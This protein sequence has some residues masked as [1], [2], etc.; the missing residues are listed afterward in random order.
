MYVCVCVYILGVLNFI[1]TFFVHTGPEYYLEK[2]RRSVPVSYLRP[3]IY[4]EYACAL[5]EFSRLI[6]KIFVWMF[7]LGYGLPPNDYNETIEFFNK[8]W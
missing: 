7:D 8:R 2:V 4:K 5:E 1:V 3:K 6:E